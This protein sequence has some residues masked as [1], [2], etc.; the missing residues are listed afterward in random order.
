[1]HDPAFQEA[2]QESR[3]LGGIRKRKEVAIEGA[4]DLEGIASVEEIRHLVDIAIIDIL[5]LDTS[6]ARCRL[7]LQAA[8]VATKLL[9]TGELEERIAALEAAKHQHQDAHRS[10]FELDPEFAAPFPGAPS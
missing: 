6:P 3:R 4:Y 1:M 7:I 2:V 8:Q 9:E 5:G 10:V